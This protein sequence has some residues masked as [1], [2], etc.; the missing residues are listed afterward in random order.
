MP[1]FSRRSQTRL[2]SCDPRLRKV[3]AKVIEHFDCT[4]LCGHRGPEAQE[5]AFQEKRSKARWGQS[6][7]NSKPSLAADVAPYNWREMPVD[8]EDRDRF[9]YFSG[10]V[11]GV[12]AD[13]GVT[14]RWGGDWD[15]DTRVDDNKFD[16]LVHFEIVD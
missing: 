9:H 2:D 15:R 1:S 5:K 12:A 6:P 13:M 3:F 8:W 14:L 16:D 11:M 7:H 10:F 4:V